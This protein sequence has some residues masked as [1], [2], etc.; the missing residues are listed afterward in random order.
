MVIEGTTSI[1]INVSLAVLGVLAT[2]GPSIFPDFIPG[3]EAKA[4]CQTAGLI[5]AIVGGVN[6]GLHRAGEQSTTAVQPKAEPPTLPPK[7][8]G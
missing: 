6:A 5:C 8:G 7:S 2:A 1:V 3:A 4:I